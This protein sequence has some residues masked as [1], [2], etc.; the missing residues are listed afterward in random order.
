MPADAQHIAVLRVVI[1]EDFS[2]GL[3]DRLITHIIQVLKE[4]EG[5]PSRIAHLAAAA[6]VSG[7]EEVKTSKMSLE[8]IT[9]YWKRL[10]DDNG[11]TVPD[12]FPGEGSEWNL[13][14]LPHRQVG[15][16]GVKPPPGKGASMQLK[17]F[18]NGGFSF[19]SPVPDGQIS[20]ED[21]ANHC[22]AAVRRESHGPKGLIESNS[23][24]VSST[25]RRS[26]SFSEGMLR[27][28]DGEKVASSRNSSPS[29]LSHSSY[30]GREHGKEEDEEETSHGPEEDLGTSFED[31]DAI[32]V[33]EQVRQIKAQEQDFETFNLKIVHRKNRT[34]FEEDKSF[35]VVLNSVI[36]GRY[37]VTE[38]LGSAAFSKA[39]QAHDLHT[40]ID[41]C[42]KIIK[43]NKDFFD[44]SLDEIKLLKYVNQHDP[45][46]K[47][48]ILRLYD[49][50]YFREHLLIVCELLK[51]NLY[52]FQTFNRESGG[53]VYFT[54]P[55]LQVSQHPYYIQSDT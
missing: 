11:S 19:P 53:E 30:T 35:H 29:V 44:Q 25:K 1:G 38:H 34:G 10:V 50:F 21:S 3:A 18:A 8:D 48:H 22:N 37:H 27:D 55:R 23:M 54:M 15:I 28:R 42:V 24:D 26:D 12:L 9:K 45:G 31:E 47:Y 49:Y 52:E 17:S 41:V 2:R 51:A 14:L 20:H 46:D 4:I 5:L 7:E 16:A 36:A 13:E 43:N 40:G 39:I 32:V 6:K 33:Q